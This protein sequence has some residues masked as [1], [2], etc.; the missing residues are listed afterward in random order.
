MLAGAWRVVRGQIP[1]QDFASA[2]PPLTLLLHALPLL[3][4]PAWLQLLAGRIG[5]YLFVW[6]TSFFSADALVRAFRGDAD[7]RAID[8]WLL[9][10]AAFV[11]S[12][13][14]FPPMAWH[15]VDGL[16]FASLGVALLAR[17]RGAPSL[18]A[19]SLAL[20][21]AAL[22]KQSFYPL[23]LLAPL[24]AGLLHGRGAALGASLWIGLGASAVLAALALAGLLPAFLAQTSQSLG[25]GGGFAASGIAAYLDCS[26]AQVLVALAFGWG[27]SLVGARTGRRVDPGVA[28]AVGVAALFAT[29]VARAW[30]S[31]SSGRSCRSP[32]A[33][34]RRR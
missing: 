21:L 2:R 10:G 7:A 13:H 16:L 24:F 27:A 19:G 4:L 25:H 12:A 22:T 17:R 3:V 29:I 30:L 31:A 14:D 33:T 5:F 8:R 26:V 11:F 6:A 34:T 32:R 18:A 1:Y 9:A 23:A 20:L 28:V 15:T